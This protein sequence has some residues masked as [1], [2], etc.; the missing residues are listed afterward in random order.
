MKNKVLFFSFFIFS[1]TLFGQI[2]FEDVIIKSF[3]G[4][5]GFDIHLTDIDGDGDFDIVMTGMV[6]DDRTLLWLE[7]E[8][9]L[10]QFGEPKDIAIYES[11]T[12]LT[13]K[14]LDN[15]G[16]QDLILSYSGGN[17]INWYENLDGKGDFS[18][19]NLID[20]YVPRVSDID[21]GDID[22]DGDFD[23][24]SINTTNDEVKWHE[25]IDSFKNALNRPKHLVDN[26]LSNPRAV[27]LNDVDGDADLDIIVSSISGN[28][29]AWYQNIDGKG[30]FSSEKVIDDELAQVY[31]LIVVDL[32][33]DGDMDVVA[34]SHRDSQIFWYENTD[35]SGDF[36]DRRVVG[37]TFSFPT[38]V[39]YQDL[40]GDG[41]I[42]ILTSSGDYSSEDK[43]TTWF[44]NLDSQGNFGPQQKIESSF[45]FPNDL[46]FADL[47]L[48]GHMDI[49]GTYYTNETTFLVLHKNLG[50][51]KNEVN[52]KVQ[53]DFD[54]NGC[55]QSDEPFSYL[56]IVSE[57]DSNSYAT[58]SLNN[59]LY[60]L[61][62]DEGEHSI[63]TSSNLPDYYTID[64]QSQ[65]VDFDGL[66]NTETINFCISPNQ[67]IN[68]LNVVLIPTSENR[69]GFD[70]TYELVYKNVGTTTLD[71]DLELQF[72]QKLSFIQASE[73]TVDT[74]TN[75]VEFAF[76]D[77]LPFESRTITL[78]LNIPPPPYVE[79]GSIIEFV[80]MI[81][82]IST[83]ITKDDNVF[84]FKREVIGSY[85]P[86][87][88]TVLEGETIS[89]DEA[90]NYLNYVIRFQNTGTASAINV[91]VDHELDSNLD[92][93]TFT[94]ISSSHNNTTTLTNGKDLE[95][96]FENINLP[97][98]VANE[99]ASHGHI[100]F[101][102]KPKS[103]IAVGD[104]I[105]G[106][107]SIFFDF[108]P[109]IFTNE[110]TTEIIEEIEADFIVSASLLKPISCKGL[111]DAIIQVEASGGLEPYNYEL[112]DEND[113]IVVSQN[114]NV[115]ENLLSGN[116][117]VRVT[118]S[119]SQQ[120]SSVILTIAEPD[121][122]DYDNDGLGDTCDSDVD[123][124]GV[125]NEND[126]CPQTSLGSVVESNG[127]NSFTLPSTNFTIQSTGESCSSSNNGSI[128]I[129][130]VEN[131]EYQAT[132]VGV[133]DSKIDF[134][135]STTFEELKA[136]QYEVCITVIAQPEYEKCFTIQITEPEALSVD[137][138]IDTSSKS[139]SLT[140]NGGSTYNINLN[141]TVYNT[142]ESQIT[143]PLSDV[144][145]KILVKTDKDCQGI[146]EESFVLNYGLLVYPNPVKNGTVTILIPE[147]ANGIFQLSL[148][149]NTMKLVKSLKQELINGQVT[150]SMDDLSTG[151][152][153]LQVRTENKTYV[154]KIIKE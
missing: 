106:Q 141:G 2:G 110:V 79:L 120:V 153:S 59:G 133:S 54:S 63:T 77:L 6:E 67:I 138:K 78:T 40:D 86:N 22:G 45:L 137:S 70:T 95:F 68:D 47:N 15:D 12:N 39:F 38:T 130:A 124:D 32:D 21:L 146:Y 10:G 148:F 23:I 121:S 91:R 76:E 107:A 42:D 58:F 145:N 49:I 36:S 142:S 33:G 93:G 61:F 119:S 75:F 8:N 9:N 34:P 84:N 27:C 19:A 52:G 5:G 88:I 25:S 102:I 65:V 96:L 152:Y 60:Q 147:I 129:T 105:K 122:P 71:G 111:N 115:F 118:D 81:N 35:G 104:I 13:S 139:V 100:A 89:P 127:C 20:N 140:L 69:A 132:L 50:T 28:E 103:D 41:D 116:Y 112:L 108:N 3:E 74:G 143:L 117:V 151:L 24:A 73:T 123:G 66:G 109:P 85:D 98:S 72:D 99:P 92:W 97:D 113:N 62:L 30:N 87:D 14:D 18:Q 16:D 29:L 44:E 101:K 7:N 1:F 131:L 56:M 125:S 11:G 144:E 4:R 135:S 31:D 83:D 37:T 48:D 149:D 126:E 51:V 94:P 43:E 128:T 136:G 53:I 82:P 134:T 80:A 114:S 26:N 55:D 90:G 64:P 46:D 57:N 154:R 150:L 17:M